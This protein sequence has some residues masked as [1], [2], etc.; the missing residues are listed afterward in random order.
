MPRRLNIVRG[1]HEK[2]SDVHG[3]EIEICIAKFAV[4][5]Y[6]PAFFEQ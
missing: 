6:A 5:V 2:L 4:D 1:V 3:I